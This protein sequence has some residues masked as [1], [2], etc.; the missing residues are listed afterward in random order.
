MSHGVIVTAPTMAEAVYAYTLGAARAAGWD[1]V[2]GSLTP[3]KLADL[4]VLDRDLFAL[5]AQADP[6]AKIAETQVRM[7]VFGGEVVWEER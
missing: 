6:G 2:I 5:A 1:H 4:V 3:D 7:T